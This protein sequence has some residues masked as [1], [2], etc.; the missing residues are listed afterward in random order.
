MRRED[1][2]RNLPD[3]MENRDWAIQ[4]ADKAGV[5]ENLEERNRLLRALD[6]HL[7]WIREK[8]SQ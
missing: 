5:T 8:L 2:E 7:D 3:K 1:I 4:Y 6:D